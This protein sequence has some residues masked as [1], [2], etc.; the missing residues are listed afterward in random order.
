M[1]LNMSGRT[2]KLLLCGCL[3]G[4]AAFY[5]TLAVG[6]LRAAFF[7]IGVP[8]G[9]FSFY[10]LIAKELNPPESTGLAVAVLNFSA[11]VFI[12]L[13]GNLSGLVL[14]FW[15]EEAQRNG[16][17][18]GEAYA[19]LFAVLAAGA[20]ISLVT[21]ILIPETGRKTAPENLHPGN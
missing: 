6:W 12:A 16:M 5:R 15:K 2:I 4:F 13:F 11:F 17:F 10:S 19:W 7:M 21:G 1:R 3:F 9:F 14:S 8:A 18:P 20:L